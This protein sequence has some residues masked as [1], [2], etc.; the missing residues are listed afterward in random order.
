VAFKAYARNLGPGT[1][2]LFVT[3][4]HARHLRVR[5][6]VCLVP[7]SEAGD[8]AAPSPDTPSCEYTDVPQGDFVVV[9]VGTFIGGNPGSTA[10]IT[11]CT[12]NGTGFPDP[13]PSNDCATARIPITG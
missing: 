9:K 8:F 13:D 7:A 10:S 11:F 2:D 12:S 5:R 6:E 3:F 1:S 4:S